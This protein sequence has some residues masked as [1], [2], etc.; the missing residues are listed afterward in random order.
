MQCLKVM[1][2]IA[3]RV[4]RER[5]AGSRGDVPEEKLVNQKEPGITDAQDWKQH[6]DP[7]VRDWLN[8]NATNPQNNIVTSRQRK[9]RQHVPCDH[10][11]AHG[12]DWVGT[13]GDF[14]FTISAFLC[15][16]FF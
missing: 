2:E 7:T 10:S 6:K 9:R 14:Y 3:M 11:V 4:G 12:S 15:A 16:Q 13:T 8:M 5:V 1:A